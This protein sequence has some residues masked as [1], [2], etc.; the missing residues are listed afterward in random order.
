ML[1]FMGN[2]KNQFYLKNFVYLNM[3]LCILM[4]SFIFFDM[5]SLTWLIVHIKGSQVRIS[6]LIWTLTI[7][8]VCFNLR[9]YNK[10]YLKWSLKNRQNKGLKDQLSLNAG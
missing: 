5:M 2:K 6:K 10:T 1:K 7:P 4:N 8:E 3:C 9:K